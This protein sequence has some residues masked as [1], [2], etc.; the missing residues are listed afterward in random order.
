VT[1]K[2]RYAAF[3]IEPGTRRVRLLGVTAQPTGACAQA[4]RELAADLDDAGH[5]FACLIR[6]RDAKFTTAFDALFASIRIN[7]VPTVPQAPRRSRRKT[8]GQNR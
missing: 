5:R 4:A 2:R 3:V 7:I 8:R 6:D 1:S